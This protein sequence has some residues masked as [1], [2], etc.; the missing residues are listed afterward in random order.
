MDIENELVKVG[1]A[2]L[3]YG[4]AGWAWDP[5]PVL[6]FEPKPIQSLLYESCMMAPGRHL[7]TLCVSTRFY[8][9]IRVLEQ[10]EVISKPNS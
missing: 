9:N 7:S 10:G 6:L 4:T 2:S 5:S 1:H 8:E 3:N